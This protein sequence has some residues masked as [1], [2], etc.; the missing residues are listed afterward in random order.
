MPTV[1]LARHAMATRFELVLH[2]GDANSLRAAGEAALDEVT[3]LEGQLSLYRPGSEIAHVNARAAREPVRV[4]PEVF[5]LLW[6]AGRI[7]RETD[8]AFDITVAPLVRCWGF[9]GAGGRMPAPGEVAAARELAGWEKVQLDAETRAV[10]FARDGMMLDLGAIGKGF[11]ADRAAEILREAGVTSGLIHGGTSTVCAIGHPPDAESWKIAVD[12]AAELERRGQPWPDGSAGVVQAGPMPGGPPA[13]TLLLAD[14]ALSISAPS[15]RQFKAGGKFYGH[16]IDPRTGHPTEAALLA[17]VI[18]QSAAESDALSTAL[19]VSGSGDSANPARLQPG[20][21]TILVRQ[22]EGRFVT[23]S[24]G[25]VA[26][27]QR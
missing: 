9:M 25:F 23:R 15:G 3:R 18:S 17:A 21:K 2:G 24:S 6:H 12:V 27:P 16:V 22:E 13:F 10:R 5:S 1:S 8:G 7:S 20:L 19:L 11:A 4:S 14:E 26:N